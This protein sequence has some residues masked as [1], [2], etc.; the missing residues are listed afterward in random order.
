MM[1]WGNGMGGWAVLLMTVSNLL[2]L[3]L[4]IVG[5][6]AL[7]RYTSRGVRPDPAAEPVPPQ[8]VLAD[9]FA[10]GDIDEDEYQRRSRVLSNT[11]SQRSAG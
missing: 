3:G 9:R 7:T 11:P 4:L 1:Y 10:R 2:F 6:I 5:T 8:R